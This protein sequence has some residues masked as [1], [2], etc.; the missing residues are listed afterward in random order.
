MESPDAN[1]VEITAEQVSRFL[2]KN[3]DFFYNRDDLL[4]EMH[5][6]HES[7]KAISLLER[8]VNILRER[9]IDMRHRLSRLLDTAKDNDK[10]F[11]KTK[12]LVLDLLAA[13][14]LDELV[15]AVNN[16][17]QND[18][19]ADISSLT[20]FG[21]PEQ[22]RH[23]QA[24]VVALADAKKHIAGILKH[25]RAVCGVLRQEELAFLF[26]DHHSQVGS[27]AVVPLN[28]DYPLGILAIGSFDPHYFKSSMGTLF[29][30]YIA[31]VLNR[32]LPRHL[33]ST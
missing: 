28:A 10:L 29:L 11:D 13:E 22:H 4:L 33:L 32:T 19:Q 18:F 24:R 21:Q 15:T 20:L 31:E 2:R 26:P 12:R 3:T 16:S 17:L 7:G 25:S 6:P 1:D 5:L 9:N 27:A 23:S 8:Q 30:S 14:D